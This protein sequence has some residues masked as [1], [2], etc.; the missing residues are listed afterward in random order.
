MDR[1]SYRDQQGQRQTGTGTQMDRGR[2]TKGQGKGHKWTW[3]GMRTQTLDNFIG[4]LT[5]KIR[6]LKELSFKKF[7]KI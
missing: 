3:T 6:A 1:N 2:D 5:K 4:Q 7:Y